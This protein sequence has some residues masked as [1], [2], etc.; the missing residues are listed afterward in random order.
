MLKIAFVA[1]LIITAII[2]IK[3]EPQYEVSI[4]NK[5]VGYVTSKNDIN[6]YINENVASLE[7]NNIAFVT[8]ENSPSLKLKLVNRNI[9]EQ[10]E[11]IKTELKE[12][13]NIQYTTFAI[14]I[15]GENK[16]YVST[17]EEA[18]NVIDELKKEYDEKYTDKLGILQV[19]SEDNAE[20]LAVSNENAK[21][22]IS[23]EL[24]NIKKSNE[25]VKVAS[26]KKSVTKS[27][28]VKKLDSIN[29][30]KLSVKP[31][32]GIITSR[33][34]RRSSPGGGV[35]STNHKGLDIAAKQGT[36]IKAAASGKVTF[37]GSK[38]SLGNLVIID[39][40]NGVQTYYGHCSKLNVSTGDSVNAGDN[41]AAVGKTGAA[42]G[43]HLHFEVHLNGKIVNPQRYIY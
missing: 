23:N 9:D 34:G 21:E 3:Y 19:Y 25:T 2:L 30:I 38:G 27:S 26:T 18:Q 39:H 20:I 28:T 32:S 6:N 11:L 1:F 29:G 15:N 7:K 24:S 17:Q 13:L 5:K 35:G 41:I 40:G 14:S 36:A 43:Y 8:L 12:Q 42:T 37:A 22:S 33:Y 4:N 16:T 10:E 31:L